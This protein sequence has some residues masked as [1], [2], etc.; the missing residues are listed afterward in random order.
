MNTFVKLCWFL[1]S[2]AMGIL[3]F[4]FPIQAEAQN[5]VLYDD[6]KIAVYPAR[7]PQ[8]VLSDPA[9][10]CA[11]GTYSL[12]FDI[13]YNGEFS[14]IN[15]LYST[16]LNYPQNYSNFFNTNIKPIIEQ[17]CPN[18]F[19]N[20]IV[21]LFSYKKGS[22][23]Q[24]EEL[25]FSF[26]RAIN[27]ETRVQYY[28]G[29]MTGRVLTTEANV[30][31]ELAEQTKAEENAEIKRIAQIK[32][33]KDAAKQEDT[34][35]QRRE[36]SIAEGRPFDYLKS[37][38]YL[39]AIYTNN[40]QVQ[41]TLAREYLVEMSNGDGAALGVL[42]A[43]LASLAGDG[44]VKNQQLTVLE[45]VVSIYMGLYAKYPQSCLQP[46]WFERRFKHTDPDDVMYDENMLE[47]TR[48]PGDVRTTVYKLNKEFKG[49]CDGV[50][51]AGGSLALSAMIGSRNRNI[52]YNLGN[53]FE[54]L[55]EIVENHDCN[56]VGVKQFEKNLLSMYLQEQSAAENS[57]NTLTNV[58]LK[59][60]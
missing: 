20:Y 42:A 31:L 54:G 51:N 3:T 15:E 59:N 23:V 17:N 47:I 2:L 13:V 18:D 16:E 21:R 27:F 49:A 43:G 33:K 11:N 60:N 5:Q 44:R 8:K 55:K 10:W 46:G 14:E 53:I 12:H 28:A 19:Y 25:Q 4:N 38:K 1:S 35:E 34:Y 45:E 37:S 56:S 26:G 7:D 30:Q 6:G 39:N 24:W 32:A 22:D 9:F 58:V 52:P 57:R 36:V 29:Q 40:Y 41:N 50:C 48:L